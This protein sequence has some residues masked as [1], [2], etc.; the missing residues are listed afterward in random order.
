MQYNTTRHHSKSKFLFCV[1]KPKKPAPKIPFV[2]VP[3]PSA[4]WYA[5]KSGP[6]RPPS[7]SGRS[8]EVWCSIITGIEKTDA[9][10]ESNF[11]FCMFSIRT[12]AGVRF[13]LER[14][15][16]RD[17]P[18]KL[19]CELVAVAIGAHHGLFDIIES[20]G[21]DGFLHRQQ[22]EGIHYEEACAAFLEMCAGEQELDELF[23]AAEKEVLAFLAAS[24]AI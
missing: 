1:E 18:G 12:C 19:V 7:G 9:I 5:V 24:Q 3:F 14:W 16:R 4:K 11:A 23:A 10:L 17:F 6:L 2:E 21:C 20:K 8:T 13:A 22:K 15:H